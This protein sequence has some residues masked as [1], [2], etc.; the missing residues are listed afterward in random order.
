MDR[1]RTDIGPGIDPTVGSAFNITTTIGEEEI[2]IAITTIEIV[3]PIIETT[4][5]LEI[6]TVMEKAIEGMIDMTVGLTIEGIILDKTMVT[7]GIG[8]EV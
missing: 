7:K 1:D 3:D 4:V 6:E 5:G 8:I 2:I